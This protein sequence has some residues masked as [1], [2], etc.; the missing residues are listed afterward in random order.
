MNDSNAPSQGDHRCNFREPR[1]AMPGMNVKNTPRTLNLA[2]RSASAGDRDNFLNTLAPSTDSDIPNSGTPAML[3]GEKDGDVG[4]GATLTYQRATGQPMRSTDGDSSDNQVNDGAVSSPASPSAIQDEAGSG[5]SATDADPTA[6]PNLAETLAL[7]N[8]PGSLVAAIY[9]PVSG[10]PA[11]D[12]RVT[13][14]GHTPEAGTGQMVAGNS[15][16]RA[17]LSALSVAGQ[18]DDAAATSSVGGSRSSF[19]VQY[20][21]SAGHAVSLSFLTGEG[22][23]LGAT[24]ADGNQAIDGIGS[25]AVLDYRRF[26]GLADG[27]NTTSLA[28]LIAS[29]KGWTS[30]MRSNQTSDAAT[31][32]T[33]KVINTLKLQMNPANLGTVTATMRLAGDD[34]LTVDLRVQ[35]AEAYR[36][37]SNDQGAIADALRAQ[38]YTIDRI[39]VTLSTLPNAG[40]DASAQGNPSAFQGGQQSGSGQGGQPAS[41]RQGSGQQ[42]SGQDDG[43]L[44]RITARQ[45]GDQG[46]SPWPSASLLYL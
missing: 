8:V 13:V 27:S 19:S 41:H 9:G 39:A 25:I 7:L 36:Q 29:D 33:S 30:V 38:G 4:T 1:N 37:L 10:A 5:A 3:S 17:A 21:K 44:V 45:D 11:P 34:G 26:P 35:S 20:L 16:M 2:A 12:D 15:A 22:V 18:E 31:S 32:A 28:N 42:R 46:D 43:G 23:S 6:D 14:E 24:G 40:G